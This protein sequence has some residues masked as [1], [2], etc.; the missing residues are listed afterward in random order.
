MM[1]K[2]PQ[3]RLPETK[4]S[5]LSIEKFESGSRFASS[6]R[7]MFGVLLAL[8]PLEWSERAQIVVSGERRSSCQ[9][10][11]DRRSVE[12]LFEGCLKGGRKK[13]QNLESGRRPWSSPRLGHGRVGESRF[14]GVF[15]G[16][17]NQRKFLGHRKTRKNTKGFA[18]LERPRITRIERIWF[19]TIGSKKRKKGKG[20]CLLIFCQ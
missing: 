3:K 1:P 16:C 11:D 10:N 5:S 7:G 17:W 2:W 19:V 14:R 20:P 8:P 15:E 9:A 6:L 18:D 4:F 13:G 12:R